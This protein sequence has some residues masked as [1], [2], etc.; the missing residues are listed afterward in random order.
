[1][2]V[3]KQSLSNLL[4]SFIT[5]HIQQLDLILPQVEFPYN[6]SVN[7]IRGCSSIE[8]TAGENPTSPLDLASNPTESRFNSKGEKSW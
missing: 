7:H 4:Q 5:K 8:T 2:K 1:M 6:N 3:L